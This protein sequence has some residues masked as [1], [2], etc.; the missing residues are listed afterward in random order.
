VLLPFFLG[1]LVGRFLTSD[2]LADS[3]FVLGFGLAVT[4]M[5]VL[6]VVYEGSFVSAMLRSATSLV[7]AA[8][9]WFSV[10]G[11]NLSVK[12]GGTAVTVEFVWLAFLLVLPSLW[13]A[14]RHPVAYL[15][16]RRQKA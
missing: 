13:G 3:T 2:P 9:I 14:V 1:T 5:A 15:L 4:A 12:T 7:V 8:Y 6:A 16:L 10:D 11:G